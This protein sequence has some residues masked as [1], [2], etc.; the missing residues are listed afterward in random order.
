MLNKEVHFIVAIEDEISG[1][2]VYSSKL[3]KVKK[4]LQEI[5][6]VTDQF[7]IKM[8]SSHS[9]AVGY[10]TNSLNKSQVSHIF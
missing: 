5:K 3:E 8:I 6:V 1:G 9:Q 2:K 7:V 10:A 4:S